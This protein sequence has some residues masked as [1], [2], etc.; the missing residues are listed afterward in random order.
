MT[1]V[2]LTDTPQKPVGENGWTFQ[3][4]G[5]HGSGYPEGTAVPEPISLA[6]WVKQRVVE[7]SRDKKA[8]EAAAAAKPIFDYSDEIAAIDAEVDAL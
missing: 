7:L 4:T 6:L 3:Q 5:T 1:R 2:V 8:L